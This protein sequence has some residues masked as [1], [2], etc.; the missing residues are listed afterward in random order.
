[1]VSCTRFNRAAAS[2]DKATGSAMSTVTS[3]CPSYVHSECGRVTS[4]EKPN[5]CPTIPR[6]ISIDGELKTMFGVS[7]ISLNRLTK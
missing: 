4:S 1:M 7:P 6:T 2:P 5:P 3:F